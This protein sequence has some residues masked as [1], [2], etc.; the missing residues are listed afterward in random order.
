MRLFAVIAMLFIGTLVFNAES[1]SVHAQPAEKKTNQSKKNKKLPKKIVVKSGDTLSKIAKKHSS[2]YLRIFNANINIKNPDLI[3]PGDKIR[4]PGTKEK[5]KKRT[6]PGVNIV[7]IRS[8]QQ[9]SAN[10]STTSYRQPLAAPRYSTS[11]GSTWDRLA[12]CES[13]GNWSAN[14]GNSY[15]GGL[16]FTQSSWRSAGGSGLP[17]QAGKAEQITRAKILQARQGWGAWPACTSKLGIR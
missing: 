4:I 10:N 1:T 8:S 15:Y 11:N 16:Q 2:T 14:T 7:S 9:L 6:L 17:N 3:Y 13:G 5:L 12:Q